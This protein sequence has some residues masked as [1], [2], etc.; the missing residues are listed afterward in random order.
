MDED[1]VK[2]V[3]MMEAHFAEEKKTKWWSPVSDF[4]MHL[5]LHSHGIIDIQWG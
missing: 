5:C 3:D 1:Y 4:C 2:Y